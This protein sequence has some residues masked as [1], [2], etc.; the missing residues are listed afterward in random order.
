MDNTAVMHA[1]RAMPVA[2]ARHAV[3]RLTRVGVLELAPWYPR[4]VTETLASQIRALAA[5]RHYDTLDADAQRALRRA[6]A[7][8]LGTKI[9]NVVQ[10][11]GRTDGQGRGG[12]KT[13]TIPDEHRCP[14]CQQPY[15]TQ[16]AREVAEGFLSKL[17]KR[18]K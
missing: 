17:L 14:C 10:A 5:E 13:R 18:V 15:Q 12:G 16:R 4:V 11:L 8:E 6:I 2:P 9:Q 3:L 7:D 1:A